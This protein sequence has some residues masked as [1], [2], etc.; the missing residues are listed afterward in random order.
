[1]V[2]VNVY[3]VID[4]EDIFMSLFGFEDTV[5]NADIIRKVFDEN[6]D[7]KEFKF[8]INCNGGLVSEGLR[9]YDVLRT[10]GKTIH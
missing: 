4:K 9:I 6:P 10:S 8:N 5:F 1:M 3:K 7:E 2:E